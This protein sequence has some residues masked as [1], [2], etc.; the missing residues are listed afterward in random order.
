MAKRYYDLA[1]QTNR[2]AYLPVTL[3]LL[4]LHIRSV[5]EALISGTSSPLT[6]QSPFAVPTEG[7]TVAMAKPRTARLR[8]AALKLFS[9]RF[10]EGLAELFSGLP[11]RRAQAGEGQDAAQDTL[12]QRQRALEA[13]DDPVAWAREARER[14]GYELD[15]EGEEE[16]ESLGLGGRDSDVLESVGIV[17]LIAS[18]G[19]VLLSLSCCEHP[20]IDAIDCR[21]LLYYRGLR[22]E[23]ARQANEARRRDEERRHQQQRNEQQAEQQ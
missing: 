12:R 9:L 1:L 15:E 2:E 13:E 5:Y 19:S 10:H 4:K 21:F 3:S 14:E 16:W 6:L 17:A 22:V 20:S 8:D 7:A 11:A 18:V 23:A